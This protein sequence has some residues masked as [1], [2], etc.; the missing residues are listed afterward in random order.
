MRLVV[1]M[2]TPRT[3]SS[4]PGPDTFGAKLDVLHEHC[5]REGRDID[6]I[7]ESVMYPGVPAVRRR[8]HRCP[9]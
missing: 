9:Y 6:P 1:I 4:D 3:C 7:T 2:P 8:D 5:D